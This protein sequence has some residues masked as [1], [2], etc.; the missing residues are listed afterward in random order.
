MSYAH[1]G[2]IQIYYEAFG[3]PG[4]EV[5]LLLAGAGRQGR[6]FSDGF[7]EQIASRGYRVI[8][9]DQRD[10]G[11]SSVVST[12]SRLVEVFDAVEAGTPPPLAYGLEDL[13]QDA[14]AV[15]DAEGADCAHLIGRSLGSGVAQL[16]AL[17]QLERVRSLTLIIAFSRS[18]S[19]A[20]SREALARIEAEQIADVEA[21]VERQ[22]RGGQ[23]MGSP[24][25][26]DADRLA[27][28]ARAAFARGVH[29]GA[30]ARHF[31]AAVGAPDLRPRLKYLHIPA[32]VIHGAL[33]RTIPL[34]Y[35]QETAAALPGAV[36]HVIP[37]MG[38]DG[39]PQLLRRWAA[40]FLEAR[41]AGG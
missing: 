4:H 9:F 27:A 38:H 16:M 23:A 36:L 17:S 19:G 20:M 1:N 28:E 8:R 37:E 25:Y 24:A 10:T 30:T 13:A 26:F 40:L 18:L 34:S 12:P 14:F 32:V 41:G 3:Q 15:L 35:A 2:A 11:L 33:D 5:V 39:P 6:D 7:C 22:V 31:A 21:Y 29:P